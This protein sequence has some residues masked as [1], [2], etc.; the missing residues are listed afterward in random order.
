MGQPL[1]D[2]GAASPLVSIESWPCDGRIDGQ[3]S[4]LAGREMRRIAA[5]PDPEEERARGTKEVAVQQ[6]HRK[7]DAPRVA[8]N[9][10][11]ELTLDPRGPSMR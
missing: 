10:R 3:T 1:P 9:P 7:Y 2:S 8:S 4:R 11:G 5:P 6:R